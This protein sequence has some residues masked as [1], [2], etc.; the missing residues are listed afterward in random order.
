MAVSTLQK[1]LLI[2]TITAP[3]HTVAGGSTNQ[4]SIDCS[5][6]G[7][8]PIG[9]LMFDT[10]VD[11]SSQNQLNLYTWGFGGNYLVVGYKNL[12][13][14]QVTVRPKVTILYIKN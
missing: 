6:S 13:T 3:S 14:S 8:T 10:S 9:L 4:Q 1:D 7:Y 11:G 2:R 5:Y 12:I